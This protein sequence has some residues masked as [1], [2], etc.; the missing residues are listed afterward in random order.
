MV[1]LTDCDLVYN[2]RYKST[3]NYILGYFDILG[4]KARVDAD[5]QSALVNFKMIA[6]I[7]KQGDRGSDPITVF[8]D[9]L[10]FLKKPDV[11]LR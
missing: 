8:Q 10:Q 2:E 3:G 1:I 9:M 11:S 4:T 6:D 7:L 5:L